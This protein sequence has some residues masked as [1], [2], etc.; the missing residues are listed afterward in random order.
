MTQRLPVLFLGH[1][2]PMTVIT[3]GPERRAWQA[4]GKSLPRPCAILVISAHWE[5]SGASHLTVGEQPRTIHDF[6]GFPD[7]LFAIQYPAP[8]SA[9][10]VERVAALLGEDRIRR[11]DTWGFDHGSWGVVR[12]MYPAAEIPMVQLSLDRGLP[13]EEHIALGRKLAPLR[14]EGVLIIGSG[15]VVHNLRLWRQFAGT[16]PDWAVDFQHRINAAMLA[17]DEA[18][19]TRFTAEDQAAMAAINSAEHYLPLLYIAGA[20]VPGDEVGVFSDS[21]DGALSMTSYLIGDTALLS[22]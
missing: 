1:G 14:D 11:D 22:T 4:L 10:L 3:D 5:T 18:A 2:S 13:A 17:G 20:R 15:N 16:R 9:E 12:P 6:G 8:G 19:L 7:E 21:I